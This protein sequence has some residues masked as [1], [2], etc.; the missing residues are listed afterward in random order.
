MSS[1]SRSNL[2]QVLLR[3]IRELPF[4]WQS[5]SYLW[6]VS[7]WSRTKVSA[8]LAECWQSPGESKKCFHVVLCSLAAAIGVWFWRR[9][10]SFLAPETWFASESA[11]CWQDLVQ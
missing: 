5:S 9:T 4:C 7:G 11:P 3:S 1:M 2:E 8:A 6:L 10:S